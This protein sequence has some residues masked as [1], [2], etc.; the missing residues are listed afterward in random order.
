[1]KNAQTTEQRQA[2]ALNPM[3]ARLR[4]LAEDALRAQPYALRE[5]GGDA[6]PMLIK[7]SLVK[8][9]SA[10][11]ASSTLPAL[12]SKDGELIR[13]PNAS[14]AAT[15][16]T[17]DAALIRNSRVA[18]AGAHMFIHR[19]PTRAV[20]TGETGVIATESRASAFRVIEAA[21]FSSVDV[22]S[23]DE[24]TVSALPVH[25]A[26]IDFTQAVAKSFR[27]E[28]PRSDRKDVSM[29]LIC[30]ELTAALTLGLARAADELLLSKISE[31]TPANFTLALAASQG[32]RFAELSAIVGTS[33]NGAN[34]SEDGHLRAAG[35]SAQLTDAVS[36]TIVGAFSRAAVAIGESV[37]IYFQRTDK[38]GLIQATAWSSML[39]LVPDPSKFWKLP[40]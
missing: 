12:F 27:V 35:I 33:G 20:A 22:D 2:G 29:E 32:L 5:R 16:I 7:Q 39:A 30:C 18:Q 10:F 3:H 6:E 37:D 31:A 19:D 13:T 36:P 11:L 25:V 40:A 38:S 15:T 24:V 23:E 34:V 26:A 21:K 17:L 4:V 1:M 9:L 28:I 14:L 8:G